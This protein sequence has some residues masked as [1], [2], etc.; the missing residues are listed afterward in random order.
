MAAYLLLNVLGL[1]FHPQR[2]LIVAVCLYPQAL[3]IIFDAVEDV[4]WNIDHI[5]KP[6]M[7]LCHGIDHDFHRR[8]MVL[9]LELVCQKIVETARRL[10]ELVPSECAVE[11]SVLLYEASA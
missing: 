11:D 1:L 9:V 4:V 6:P 7:F 10:L 2:M 5:S 8:K 3:K